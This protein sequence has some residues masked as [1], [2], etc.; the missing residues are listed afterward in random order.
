MRLTK[1]R[2]SLQKIRVVQAVRNFETM[3]LSSG[4]HQ[5]A[6]EGMQWL[7]SRSRARLRIGRGKTENPHARSHTTVRVG[8]ARGL[9]SS[10][11]WTATKDGRNSTGRLHPGEH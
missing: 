8:G 11:R 3:G 4:A 2:Q 5:A 9:A 7:R 6:Q 10:W 1:K